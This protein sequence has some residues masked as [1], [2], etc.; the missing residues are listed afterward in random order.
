MEEILEIEYRKRIVSAK[1][2]STNRSCLLPSCRRV[3]KSVRQVFVEIG[4]S[5]STL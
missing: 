3:R 4:T 5:V 1:M 2:S